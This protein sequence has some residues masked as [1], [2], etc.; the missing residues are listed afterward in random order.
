D[1]AVRAVVEGPTNEVLTIWGPLTTQA[2]RARRRAAELRDDA[3]AL[4]AQAGQ[5]VKRCGA[6][7]RADTSGSARGG[8]FWR[9]ARRHTPVLGDADQRAPRPA[10]GSSPFCPR[11]A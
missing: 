11:A 3:Q 5:A 8:M 2:E 10:R 4:R 7:S 9:C 6:G 1:W